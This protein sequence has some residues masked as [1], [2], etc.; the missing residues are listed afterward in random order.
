[1][2]LL[3]FSI[4]AHPRIPNA[5]QPQELKDAGMLPKHPPLRCVSQSSNLRIPIGTGLRCSGSGQQI[6]PPWFGART[7]TSLRATADKML[8]V[9]P[10]PRGDLRWLTPH[11]RSH[12]DVDSG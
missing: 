8:F 3:S 12:V 2:A 10:A 6:Y 1:M 5:D 7:H 11:L 9:R 4:I